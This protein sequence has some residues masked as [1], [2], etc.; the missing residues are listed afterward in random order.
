MVPMLVAF[1]AIMYF[2]MIRPQQKRERER[3]EMLSSITKGDRVVTN[4]G[5][6]GDVVGLTDTN[7]VLRVD[8][9]CKIEFV[10]SAIAQVMPRETKETK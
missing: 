7:V 8:E 4:G 9:N 1:F 6:C 3:R 2:L 5:I 10:R